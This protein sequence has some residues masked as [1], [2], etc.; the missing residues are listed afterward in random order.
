MIRTPTVPEVSLVENSF[1]G[2]LKSLKQPETTR[3]SFLSMTR[4]QVRFEK[5][6]FTNKENVPDL[7]GKSFKQIYMANVPD[8]ELDLSVLENYRAPITTQKYEP[9][10]LNSIENRIP[11]RP[12]S[13]EKKCTEIAK[14]DDEPTIKDLFRVIQQQNEQIMLLQQQVNSLKSSIRPP[15]VFHTPNLNLSPT[16]KGV[17]SIIDVKT[18]NF[19]VLYHQPKNR[20]TEATIQEIVDSNK[21]EYDH[22]QNMLRFDK[23]IEVDNKSMT[24]TTPNPDISFNG[25]PEYESSEYVKNFILGLLIFIREA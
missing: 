4:K 9:Q 12:S 21:E 16:K 7:R 10:V 23:P 19:E 13:I 24:S 25:L 15:E 1:L 17:I 22:R 20:K 8:T 5:P 11:I 3:D 2:G 6:A 18:A 14:T